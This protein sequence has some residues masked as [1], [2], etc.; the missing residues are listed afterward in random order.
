M[1]LLFLATVTTALASPL[2][3]TPVHYWRFEDLESPL[4]DSVGTCNLTASLLDGPTPTHNDTYSVGNYVVFNAGIAHQN[5]TEPKQ[6]KAQ[7]CMNDDLQGAAGLTVEFLLRP[8]PNCFL[9]G[10]SATLLRSRGGTV[11]FT[12]GYESII[13]TAATTNASVPSTLSFALTG[14]G[15]L[16]ADYLWP[17]IT[18]KQVQGGWHHFALVRDARTGEFSLME[19]VSRPCEHRRQPL[20][21]RP[22]RPMTVWSRLTT[23]TPWHCVLGWMNWLSTTTP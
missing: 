9:R 21:W 7:A 15:V 6:W 14:E 18:H 23:G 12:I 2:I 17:G 11:G 19:K 5:A 1:S 16:A 10:G 8:T 4:V 3:G 22:C 20:P 13:F